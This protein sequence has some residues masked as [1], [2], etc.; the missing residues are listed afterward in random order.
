[1]IGY[2]QIAGRRVCVDFT[3]GSSVAIALDFDGAQPSFF[4]A[5]TA[6]RRA[7]RIGDFIGS[8]AAGGSCNVSVVTLTPHCN[9]THTEGIGHIVDGPVSIHGCLRESLMPAVLVTIAPVD[10]SGT[11]ES[12][13]PA[14]GSRDR[15]VTGRRLEEQLSRYQD[16]ELTGVVIRTLPNGPMKMSCC[17]DG[18][19]MP[20]FLTLDAIDYLNE[21][22]VRHL[23]V[24]LPSLDRMHDDG[25]LSAHHRFW[26]VPEGTRCLTPDS[27]DLKTVTELIYAPNDLEDGAYILDLQVA[28]FSCDAAPSRPV[29]Y[30]VDTI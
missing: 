19:N 29:L 5:T 7:M 6:R 28:P 22:G 2:F 3:R 11:S 8:T 1:M 12:Y 30:A 21:R 15:V 16:A 23:L 26:R 20:P 9:G 10:A 17:Y 4:G 27:D 25:L 14:L 13:R 24:D 18:D